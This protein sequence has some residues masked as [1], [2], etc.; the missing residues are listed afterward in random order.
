MD[1]SSRGPLTLT[2]GK[3]GNQPIQTASSDPPTAIFCNFH[4]LDHS[5]SMCPSPCAETKTELSHKEQSTADW[6]RALVLLDS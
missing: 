4:W 3:V 6:V 5:L 2:D 1:N